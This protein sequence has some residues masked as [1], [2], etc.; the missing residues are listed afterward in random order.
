[1]TRS[2]PT[3]KNLEIHA[4]LAS[5]LIRSGSDLHSYLQWLARPTTQLPPPRDPRKET[6]ESIEVLLNPLRD[7]LSLP[8]RR[9]TESAGQ[10]YASICDYLSEEG[11]VAQCGWIPYQLAAGLLPL[12]R[13]LATG[14]LKEG[15]LHSRRRLSESLLLL[16]LVEQ[17]GI[18]ELLQMTINPQVSPY[19]VLQEQLQIDLTKLDHLVTQALDG[20]EPHRNSFSSEVSRMLQDH[21]QETRLPVEFQ[22]PEW[23]TPQT[24]WLLSHE[25]MSARSDLNLPRSWLE[26]PAPWGQIL[27]H[28][29]A[30]ERVLSQGGLER[31]LSKDTADDLVARNLV[32]KSTCAPGQFESN[33]VSLGSWEGRATSSAA[34]IE[35]LE[36]MDRMI[37]QE[38]RDQ[39]FLG[40]DAAQERRCVPKIL[41]GE[42]SGLEDAAFLSVVKRR[43]AV[44]RSEARSVCLSMIL[45]LPDADLASHS[46]AKEYVGG[47]NRWQQKIVN[48]LADHPSMNEPAAFVTSD[49]QLI[50]AVLD[51]ERNEMTAILRQGLIEVLAGSTDNSPAALNQVN[52]PARFH[53]GIASTAAPSASF[54]PRELILSTHRCL[55]AA[56]RLGKAS[57]KSIEVF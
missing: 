43:V 8:D 54:D 33:P 3:P 36:V 5:R 11:R 1:M 34:G 16:G 32:S 14:H 30:L 51:V 55:A 7:G 42:I 21:Q 39:A 17:L 22:T 2:Q 9:E 24:L 41:I 38:L 23:A 35:K 44:S 19:R 18:E 26:T 20:F 50:V 53:V 46:L 13:T 6:T 10:W 48:W 57:I 25:L 49:G 27:E 31:C 47:L 45:V 56:Q 4:A 12:Y 37:E 29:H 28:W 15:F 40:I 52:V